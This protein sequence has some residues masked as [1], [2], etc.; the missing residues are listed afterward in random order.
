M[1]ERGKLY[2]DKMQASA[3]RMF[4]L[5]DGVLN[6]SIINSLE[7]SVEAVD[8]NMV[9]K[10]IKTD[11]EVLLEETRGEILTKELPTLSGSAVLLNQLFYNLLNNALKFLK[12][13][14]P[15]IIQITSDIV[16]GK[17]YEQSA[18]ADKEKTFAKFSICANANGYKPE[19]AGRIFKTFTRL[20][21]RDKFEGT[22]LGLALCKKIAERHGGYIYATGKEGEGACFYVF[23]PV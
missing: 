12:P 10:N 23:L 4:G 11:L 14:V 6:Y 1:P 20:N 16:L 19:H 18:E 3:E 9:F 7:D 15:P 5:I 22:G 17:E 2:L 13:G 8:L 21:S